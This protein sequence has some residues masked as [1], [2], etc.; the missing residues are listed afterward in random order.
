MAGRTI[1]PSGFKFAV[2][3]L[4]AVLSNSPPYFVI[5]EPSKSI[6]WGNNITNYATWTIDASNEISVFDVELGRLSTDGLQFIARNVPI[7]A[8]GLP[9]MLQDVPSG[10]DYYLI[11][12]NVTHGVVYS[13]SQRFSILSSGNSLSNPSKAPSVKKRNQALATVTV[14]GAPNPTAKNISEIEPQL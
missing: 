12:L 3:S 5:N 7:S 1:R 11:F 4:R 8:P 14:S 10:D 6:Q 2:S 9:I 13:V